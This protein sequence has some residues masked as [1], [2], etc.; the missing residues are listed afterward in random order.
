[1]DL[2]P[3]LV[4][5]SKL[6]NYSI[7][8]T[9][10]EDLGQVQDLMLDMS[11]GQIAYAIIS[12]GG[13][14]GVSDKWFAVPWEAMTWSPENKRLVLNV[15]RELLKNAPGLDKTRW[16]EELDSKW[17]GESSEYFGFPAAWYN[18]PAAAETPLMYRNPAM[19]RPVTPDVPIIGVE[20]RHT[21]RR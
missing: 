11:T 17:L 19:N 1:M 8:N 12:F 14:L 10:G 21:P 6:D 4:S 15:S 3:H 16:Q 18:Q 2:T 9:A 7:V 13:F 20:P 5:A